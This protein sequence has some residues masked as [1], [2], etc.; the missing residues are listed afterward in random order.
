M[1]RKEIKIIS[2]FYL[3]YIYY[4]INKIFIIGILLV[5]IIVVYVYLR[6][7]AK[8]KERINRT[9]MMEMKFQEKKSR[10]E[11]IR[12]NSKPCIIPNLDSPRKCLLE[13]NHECIW[14]DL[15]ERC[16]LN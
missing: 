6:S 9:N 16:D 11:K 13:S 2:R 15:A 5:T 10:L 8:Y 12:S 1:F 7:E 3:S 4:M 14:N